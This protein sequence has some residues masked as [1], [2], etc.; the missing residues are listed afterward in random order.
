MS[1]MRELA[2]ANG[3]PDAGAGL[4]QNGSHNGDQAP[5]E[6]DEMG[7]AIRHSHLPASSMPDLAT[8]VEPFAVDPRQRRYN[9]LRVTQLVWLV[10]WSLEALF[11]I[12]VLLKLI[13]ANP[14]AGFAQ[15]IYNMTAVFLTPFFGLTASPSANGAVLE[16]ST[17]I[18]MMVYALL[19]WAVVRVM[20]LVFDAPTVQ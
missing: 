18:A 3:N 17:L 20:W 15:F 8:Y 13:A 12:R 6:V 16:I 9:L 14:D 10:T 19:A 1:E 7:S 2:P 11:G 4:G 5:S